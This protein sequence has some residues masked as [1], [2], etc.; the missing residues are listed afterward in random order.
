MIMK[1][2]WKNEINDCDS[3]EINDKIRIIREEQL[4]KTKTKKPLQSNGKLKKDICIQ[5]KF[6]IV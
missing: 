1:Y 5:C 3:P 6:E 2:I 4:K